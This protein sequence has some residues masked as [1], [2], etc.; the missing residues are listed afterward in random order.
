LTLPLACLSSMATR[1]ILAEL[2]QAYERRTGTAVEVKSVGGVDAARMVRTGMAPDVVILASTAMEALA[3]EGHLEANSLAPVARSGMAVAVP[4]G[5]PHPRLDDEPALRSALL[6][7]QSVAY[8]TGP[9]GDHL[10]RLL[11]RWRVR[12]EMA[13]RLVQAPPGVSV[14]SMLAKGEATLGV[15]QLSE[16]LHAPGI[17]IVGPLPPGAQH[18]TVFTAGLRNGER[19]PQAKAWIAFLQ[20][21]EARQAKLAQGMGEA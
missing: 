6:A 4:A 5:A 11:D 13:G 9:S 2:A 17:E 16:L 21:A 12:E 1:V 8:S 3:G 15:Q 7:S 18:E 14:A 20:S 10:V 19:H